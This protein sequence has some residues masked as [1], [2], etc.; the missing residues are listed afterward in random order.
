MPLAELIGAFVDVDV[1]GDGDDDGG[2]LVARSLL[3]ACNA[4]AHCAK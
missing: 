2:S 4:S 1:D 3:V